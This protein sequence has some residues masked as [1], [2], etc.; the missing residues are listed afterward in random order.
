[1]NKAHVHDEISVRIIKICDEGLV[2]FDFNLQILYRSGIF[3]KYREKIN[4]Y[5]SL[6]KEEVN[7]YLPIV[8]LLLL[9]LYVVKLLKE[10]F[11]IHLTNFLN[12]N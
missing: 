10:S 6:K 2:K 1:M 8:D 3:W 12:K 7:R 4:Y 11:S 5:S 9:F